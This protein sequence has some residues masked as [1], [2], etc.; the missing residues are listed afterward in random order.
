M[1]RKTWTATPL[2][3]GLLALVL[4]AP[5]V[6]AAEDEPKHDMSD[7]A[8][9]LEVDPV[10]ENWFGP[11]PRYDDQPYDAEKQLDIYGKKFM[12]KTAKPPIDLGIR[13]Y[14]R[15][16][17]TP[18]ATWLG[19]KN[20]IN[21]HFMTYGD[22][23][24]AGASYNGGSGEQSVLAARLNLDMDLAITATERLHAFVRPID[25]GKSFTRYQIR[26]P[27]EGKFIHESNFD[28]KTL[29]FEGDV[30]SIAQGFTNRIN[31][32]DIPFALGRVP[33]FTQNGI[34]LDDAFDGVATGI[35]AKNSPRLDISNTDITFFAGLRGVT[36]GASPL[37]DNS[38]KV[39]GLAGFVDA[40]KGYFEYGYGFTSAKDSDL[41]YHNLTA[42]FSRRYKGRLSNSVRVIGNFGQKGIAGQKTADGA[43]LLIENSI[44]PRYF[45][46]GS[47]FTVLNFVPYVNLFAGFDSPQPLARAVD[48]GGVLKNTGIN[49]ESDG[50]TAY[51]TL[52]ATAKKSYG[53]ALGVEY[54][55]DL[56]RQLVF[57]AAAVQRMGS[58]TPGNGNQYAFGARYQH[59][60]GNA[61]IV[62]ADAMKGWRQGQKDIYG[63]R[64]EIRRKF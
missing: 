25:N 57:E 42:A 10:A 4:A 16:A 19:Q 29:F 37:T 58:V 3:A 12:N 33:L 55:F 40:R 34:W 21:F 56:S 31:Q 35:T 26:G 11:E 27:D 36:T 53:G 23:R 63:V 50:L 62:R 54:L 24:V 7:Q 52:D 28:L 5:P 41:S 17:Y 59:K 14:D 20:P 39:F 13:M 38:N 60:I 43:L 49:F 47:K 6:F 8:K 15:G 1:K 45:P 22:V 61:W 18:R 32:L 2:L 9:I 51:P 64:L 30:G 46:Y 48:S 44:I